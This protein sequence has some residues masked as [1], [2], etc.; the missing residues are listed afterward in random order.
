MNDEEYRGLKEIM[1][2]I[3]QNTTDLIAFRQFIELTMRCVEEAAADRPTMSNVVKEIEMM[4]H[5]DC[6]DTNST[7]ATSSATDFGNTKG[8]P[9]HP[10][11]DSFPRKEVSSGA[12]EYSGGYTP[13]ANPEPK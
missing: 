7:S 13:P 3:I 1:D 12:F 8:D 2:P 10:Y 5:D 11:N 6:L 9:H 4:L